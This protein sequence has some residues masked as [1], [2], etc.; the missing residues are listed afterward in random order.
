[1]KCFYCGAL[2]DLAGRKVTFRASCETCGKDLHSCKNCKYYSPGK[3]NDCAVPGTLYISDREAYNFCEDFAPRPDAPPAPKK[4]KDT[5]EN[6][7]KD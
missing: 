4:G 6:L 2:Q 1:M 3:P 5:F 7:F